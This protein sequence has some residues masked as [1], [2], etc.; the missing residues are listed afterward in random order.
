MFVQLG[1]CVS[2]ASASVLNLNCCLVLLPM[3]RVLLAFL[4]GS[5]KVSAVLGMQR[6]RRGP[7]SLFGVKTIERESVKS[8]LFYTMCL[9]GARIRHLAEI[10]DSF[11]DRLFW[12]DLTSLE[13]GFFSAFLKDGELLWS[14][15]QMNSPLSFQTLLL[16]IYVSSQVLPDRIQQSKPNFVSA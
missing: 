16:E 3:C 7:W 2:R 9:H 8:C 12:F 14:C 5:Q 13:G 10:H 11:E 1:L 4:R 6:L 15:N